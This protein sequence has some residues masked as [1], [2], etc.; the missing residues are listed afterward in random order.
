MGHLRG[1]CMLGTYP[2]LPGDRCRW[3]A[4]DFDGKGRDGTPPE[5]AAEGPAVA[6]EQARAFCTVLDSHKI[7]YMVNTSRSAK[8][9]H[10]RVVFDHAVPC[11]VARAMMQS[12][13]LGADLHPSKDGIGFDRIFPVADT[14]SGSIGSQVA[15]PLNGSALRRGGTAVLDADWKPIPVGPALWE[16]LEGQRLLEQWH[17]ASAAIAMGCRQMLVA[18]QDRA[19]HGRQKDGK[20]QLSKGIAKV[21]A[22]CRFFSDVVCQR[23]LSYAEWIFLASQL[24]QF[25]SGREIFHYF[26]RQDER[27]YVWGYADRVFDNIVKRYGPFTCSWLAKNAWLC[28]DLGGDDRCTKNL[29]SSGLGAKTPAT[30]TYCR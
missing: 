2:H 29:L 1:E 22:S 30:V 7:P 11:F 21:M 28:P 5:R 24:G 12:A 18:P 3:T 26:S 14:L 20:R 8:G 6:R 19:E 13:L 9:Y 4:A 25:E 16:R 23:P 15:M 17:A 10:V 27:R